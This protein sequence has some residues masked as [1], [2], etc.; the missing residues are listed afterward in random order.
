[1]LCWFVFERGLGWMVLG[2][3]LLVVGEVE[4]WSGGRG[5]PGG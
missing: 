3:W 1:V 2:W 5:W 4:R